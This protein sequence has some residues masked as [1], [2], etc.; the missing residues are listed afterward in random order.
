MQEIILIVNKDNF[1]CL[2]SL[3]VASCGLEVVRLSKNLVNSGNNSG[4]LVILDIKENVSTDNLILYS[5]KI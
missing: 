5:F 4:I 3:H 1:N 2:H